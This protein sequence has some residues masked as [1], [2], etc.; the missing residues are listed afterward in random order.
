MSRASGAAGGVWGKTRT[1]QW[2][3]VATFLYAEIGLIL[4]SCLPFIPP[5]R[6]QKIFSFSVWCKIAS[7]WNKAF[8]TIIILLIVVSRCCWEKIIFLDSYYWKDLSQQTCCLWTYTN[9]TLQVSK[10]SSHFWIF[11][12]FLAS[13]ETSG[14]PYY[15]AGRRAVKQRST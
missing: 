12:I 11:I 7:F 8:L 3:A 2:A 4:I 5:Q 14:Y 1:L 9:E 13:V 6:W 10:K 15:S